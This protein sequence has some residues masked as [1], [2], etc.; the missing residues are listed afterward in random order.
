MILGKLKDSMA[1][2]DKSSAAQKQA[3]EDLSQLPLAL[4]MENTAIRERIKDLYMSSSTT[5]DDLDAMVASLF[6]G[7]ETLFDVD[8]ALLNAPQTPTTSMAILAIASSPAATP[9]QLLSLLSEELEIAGVHYWE[10]RAAIK[11]NLMQ[12]NLLDDEQLPDVNWNKKPKPLKQVP[13][14]WKREYGKISVSELLLVPT[15]PKKQAA[16]TIFDSG[17]EGRAL[18]S[19]QMEVYKACASGGNT[20]ETEATFRQNL[21]ALKNR[22]AN[23]DAFLN[24]HKDFRKAS[25]TLMNLIKHS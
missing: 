7:T 18:L 17:L 19:A 1:K 23:S 4:P 20:A 3:V 15:S 24:Q 13:S 16:I 22:K 12:Q 9:F 10:L 6:N 25:K 8:F 5:P 21:A 14:F 11:A 2:K